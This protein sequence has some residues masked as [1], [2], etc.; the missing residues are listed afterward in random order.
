MSSCWVSCGDEWAAQVLVSVRQ[1]LSGGAER[2]RS[3]VR[4]W[5][6]GLGELVRRGGQR[7]Q[8]GDFRFGLDPVPTLG[9]TF[10]GSWTS[11]GIA[12]WLI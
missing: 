6:G 12:R 5:A 7:W 2:Q 4:P 1:G 11:P 10:S 8:T 3:R 9:H